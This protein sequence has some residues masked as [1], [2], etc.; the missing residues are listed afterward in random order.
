[1]ANLAQSLTAQGA[2]RY[3]EAADLLHGALAIQERVHGRVHPRVAFILN[4]LGNLEYRR[5]RFGDAETAFSRTVEIYRAAYGNK[6]YRVAVALANLGSVFIARE[7]YARAEPL[8]REAIDLY[9]VV[10]SPDHFNTAVARIKLGHLLV[11]EQRYAEAEPHLLAGYGILTK[12]ATPSPTWLKTARTDLATIYEQARQPEKA[13]KFRAE[14][15]TA[16]ATPAK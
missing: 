11:R 13:E 7:E 15:L 14:L 3:D 10:L 4:E 5:N 6:S 2:A 16:A 9:G 8:L 12:Q 1:M